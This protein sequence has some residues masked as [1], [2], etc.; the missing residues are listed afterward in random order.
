[1]IS[2]GDKTKVRSDCMNHHRETQKLTWNFSWLMYA[3]SSGVFI[4]KLG[5]WYES[6]KR[7][8]ISNNYSGKQLGHLNIL[9]YV[10]DVCHKWSSNCLP[11]G[12]TWVHPM[13]SHVARAVRVSRC[14]MFCWSF[15]VIL[16][17]SF[18]HC[19]VCPS[20]WLL[21]FLCCLQTFLRY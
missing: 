8:Q 1:M 6:D 4:C 9:W 13:L 11:L 16:S 2:E 15:F 3:T 12:S 14:V 10:D 19:I 20:L 21:I 17:F 5:I 7:R 18:G